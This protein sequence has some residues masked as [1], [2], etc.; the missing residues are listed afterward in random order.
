MAAA[1]PCG[2]DQCG[3]PVA[4]TVTVCTNTGYTNLLDQNLLEFN[5]ATLI[6]E[7]AHV[8]FF[9]D[10]SWV[11]FRNSDGT[12]K[13]PNPN[14]RYQFSCTGEWNVGSYAIGAR[15]WYVD[16]FDPNNN[17]VVM[18]SP[19]NNVG[20]CPCPHGTAGNY[21]GYTTEKFRQC[22][23]EHPHCNF[24]MRTPKVVEKA[25]EYFQCASL[26][27]V[28]LEN[29]PT[30]SCSAIGNHWEQRILDGEL[31]VPSGGARVEQFVSA[32]TL[33]L[34]EDSGWYL[35]DYSRA[36]K[37]IENR[38]WGYRKGCGFVESGCLV[39]SGA[40][41][42]VPTLTS[43]FPFHFCTSSED[44]GC[45]T[46]SLG[47]EVGYCDIA[48]EAD[49]FAQ[50]FQYFADSSKGGRS[51]LLDRCPTRA[52]FLNG[53]CRT[54]TSSGTVRVQQLWNSGVDGS[55]CFH[56]R[57]VLGSGPGGVSVLGAGNTAPA[58]FRVVCENAE[59]RGSGFYD[60]Y[61]RKGGAEV[62]A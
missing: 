33:A 54:L 21:F 46:S 56:S 12:R 62:G 31:M 8:L 18:K 60:V 10:G 53:D 55:Q 57:V 11:H 27:G 24:E 35:P 4:G 23:T 58:C 52:A 17:F 34:A 26:T 59:G 48:S 40:G 44:G 15:S 22:L 1:G 29:T 50:P 38:H 14:N 47:R 61:G 51:R 3:R 45:V 20:T 28:L 5:L 16:M 2:M 32:I 39:G 49:A 19:V 43:A 30:G 9:T 13:I 7:I 41:G 42:A 6:H 36:T 25:R 37:P